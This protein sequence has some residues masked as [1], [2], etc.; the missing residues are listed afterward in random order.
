[1]LNGDLVGGVEVWSLT[2]GA[3]C[4]DD[5]NFRPI[6]ISLKDGGFRERAEQRGL[7]V[8]TLPT[9]GPLDLRRA[10]DV[11]KIVR[12]EDISLIHTHTVRANLIGRLA[13]KLARVPVVTHIHSRTLDE[14]TNVLKNWLNWRYDRLSERLTRHFIFVAPTLTR[15]YPAYPS[16]IIPNSVEPPDSS[17]ERRDLREELGIPAYA[18]TFGCIAVLRRRKGVEDLIIAAG[19][20]MKRVPNAHCLIVGSEAEPGYLDEL[21][22]IALDLG[23]LDRVHFTGYRD[24][25]PDILHTLDVMVLPSICGEGLPLIILEALHAGTPPVATEVEG[26]TLAIR[27]GETGYLVAPRDASGIADRVANLLVD[28]ELRRAMG[29][30]GIADARKRFTPERM[31]RDLHAVYGHVVDNTPG[32]LT[33]T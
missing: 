8:R 18:P 16:T 25:V 30:R 20:A 13:G 14:T 23:V 9:R 31:I 4:V 21:K 15:D 12:D 32:P 26:T 24:D 19:S 17:T 1:M 6:F 5:P 11:A 28:H 27:D 3:R 2:Y 33:S 7:D 22:S 29:A 10:R